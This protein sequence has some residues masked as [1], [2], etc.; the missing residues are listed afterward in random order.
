[1]QSNVRAILEGA[2]MSAIFLVLFF[3]AFYT[4]LSVIAAFVLPVPLSIY[5]YRHSVRMGA[6]VVFVVI[7]LSFI[8]TNFPGLFIALPAAVMGLIMGIAYRRKKPAGQVLILGTLTGLVLLFVSV[9]LAMLIV[10]MNPLADMI[11]GFHT[12]VNQMITDMQAQIDR[13]LSQIPANQRNDAQ[14]RQLLQTRE[15]LEQMKVLATTFISAVIPGVLI[16]SSFISAFMNHVFFRRILKRMGIQI[17]ALPALHDLRFPRLFLYYY[18]I[19]LFLFMMKGLQSYHYLYMVVVNVM[20]L[21]QFLISIQALGFVAHWI[22]KRNVSKGLL[23]VAVILFL[24]PPFSYI[25]LLV[26]VL[27]LGFNLRKRFFG[28]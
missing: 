4:P 23:I 3:I 10:R 25:L 22:H 9:G 15:S 19:A 1:V 18:L 20:F 21:L 14:A 28:Q 7:F 2:F 27:D 8:F 24:I 11:K 5:G 6:L 26:G 17:Q 13:S 16:F 12:L